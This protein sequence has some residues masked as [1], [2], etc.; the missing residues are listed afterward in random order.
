MISGYDFASRDVG[1]FSDPYLVLRI[2]SKKISE[3]K[4]YQLDEPNPV[5]FK[6]YDFET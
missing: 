1:G 5:F 4:N 3:S 6:H 2:G